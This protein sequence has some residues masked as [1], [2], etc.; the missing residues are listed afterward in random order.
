MSLRYMK[1]KLDKSALRE[2]APNPQLIS[3]FVFQHHR[4]PLFSMNVPNLGIFKRVS[5]CYKRSIRETE[6][7][8]MPF[9]T[10]GTSDLF[11]F[12]CRL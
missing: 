4:A 9:Y 11:S 12:C 6:D 8:G 3:H 7:T 5:I 10:K 1:L 2:A